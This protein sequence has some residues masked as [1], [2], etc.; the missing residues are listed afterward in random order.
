MSEATPC[1]VLVTGGAGLL[2]AALLRALAVSDGSATRVTA[3]WHRTPPPAQHAAAWQCVDLADAT[4]ARGMVTEL[5]PRAVVHAAVAVD[6]ASFGSVIV[7]ASGALAKAAREVGAPFV[8]VSS[9][10]VFDGAH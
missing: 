7:E 4:R 5:R 6:P 8:H 3:T 1:D 10:M 2:G 9:D